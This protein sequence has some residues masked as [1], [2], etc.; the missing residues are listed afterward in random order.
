MDGSECTDDQPFC[1]PFGCMY[2]CPE[3]FY[4]NGTSCVTDCGDMLIHKDTRTCENSCPVGTFRNNITGN[5][6]VSSC[7]NGLYK[8]E[9]ECV[10]NCGE[11]FVCNRD[12]VKQCPTGQFIVKALKLIHG[13]PYLEQKCTHTCSGSA[14]EFVF[15][16]TCVHICPTIARYLDY[17]Y[18]ISNVPCLN[19]CPDSKSFKRNVTLA[20]ITYSKC[21]E[22]CTGINMYEENGYCVDQCSPG[23]VLLDNAC[24]NNCPESH[25]V[26][27]ERGLCYRSCENYTEDSV[28]ALNC[29]CPIEKPFFYQQHCLAMCPDY[30]SM[31]SDRSGVKLCSESCTKG[32]YSLNKT[33]VEVCPKIQFRFNSTCVTE[34]PGDMPFSCK[35]EKGSYNCTQ[36]NGYTT[37]VTSLCVKDCPE[38]MF[39]NDYTCTI[40]CPNY[41]DKISGRCQEKCPTERPFSVN[42][43]SGADCDWSGCG[44]VQIETQMCIEYCPA[45]KFA[46][47]KDCL[48]YC[49][50][51]FKAFNKTCLRNCP[52]HSLSTEKN[53][54]F[55]S[56]SMAFYRRWKKNTTYTYRNRMCFCM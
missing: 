49:P 56:Y 29:S 24:M 6:C 44:S 10:P 54:N 22:S 31:I 9:T 20:S 45:D 32:Q 15:N 34:C 43:T 8:H 41:M 33:C 7:P 40:K 5:V 13:E 17:T 19:K 21:E 39:K 23:K 1:T 30:A 37:D 18:F 12:C 4:I 42:L 53:F 26:L 35:A 50:E 2:D 55:Y 14:G 47:G 38:G 3:P 11:Q 25:P 16:N 46:F 51:N 28:T 36:S 48:D 27:S 52:N